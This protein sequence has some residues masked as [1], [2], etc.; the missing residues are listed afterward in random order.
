MYEK[1][2]HEMLNQY[3]INKTGN[4]HIKVTLSHARVTTVAVEEQ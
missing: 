1:S 3:K 2:K 4:V